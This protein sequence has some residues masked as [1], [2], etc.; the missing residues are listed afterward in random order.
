MDIFRKIISLLAGNGSVISQVKT[1]YCFLCLVQTLLQITSRNVKNINMTVFVD[2][3]TVL[4][5][6]IAV[7]RGNTVISYKFC[8]HWALLIY[9]NL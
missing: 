6:Q 5:C 9:F 7:L 3:S 4:N 2:T 8:S 1:L